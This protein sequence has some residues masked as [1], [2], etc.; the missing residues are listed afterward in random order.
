[1]DFYYMIKNLSSDQTRELVSF[2]IDEQTYRAR[3]FPNRFIG[4]D[5]DINPKLDFYGEIESN[6]QYLWQGFI[7]KDV[8]IIYSCEGDSNGF[9]V[10]N[11]CYYY[12]DNDE[13]IYEFFEY[14]K[15]IDLKN[16]LDF[17]LH[18]RLFIDRYFYNLKNDGVPRQEYHKP[19]VDLH[20]Q[21]IPR[22]DGHRFLDFKDANN[23]ECSEY[24]AMAENILSIFG[25][26]TIFLDGSVKTNWEKG[27][28][29][30]NLVIVNN[31][32][33]IV[34]FHIPIDI[35][36]INHNLLNQA[37]FMGHIQYYDLESLRNHILNKQP[38]SFDDYTIMELNSTNYRLLL[39]VKREYIAG[40]AEY[41]DE[42]SLK[43]SKQNY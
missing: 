33:F 17:F 41:Y 2:K 12:I 25:Y 28:H 6:S 27:G 39:D 8:R 40:N 24:S 9:A 29:S 23:A 37:P 30:F 7:P 38:F 22:K 43:K 32:V 11:G 26:Q 31:K 42:K 1:M 5:C 18:L 15:Q 13:Y 14:I 3:V 4:V 21:N 16:T 20:E 35:I 36:D 19:I 34:D 10:N